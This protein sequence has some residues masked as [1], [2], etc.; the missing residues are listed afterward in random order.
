MKKKMRVFRKGKHFKSAGRK[1][2]P[3]EKATDEVGGGKN[4][5][6]DGGLMPPSA[7]TVRARSSLTGFIVISFFVL[8]VFN[9]FTAHCSAVTLLLAQ[10]ALVKV[11]PDY[12]EIVTESKIFSELEINAVKSRLGGNPGSNPQKNDFYFG[13]KDGKKVGAAIILEEPGKFG[14]MKIAVGLTME[15]EVY[16]V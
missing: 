4:I 8:I 14:I 6:V 3:L 9:I 13:V 16:A 12:D 10:E 2:T 7:E 1:F 11:L 15:G 5:D